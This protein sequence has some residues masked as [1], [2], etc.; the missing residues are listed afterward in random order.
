MSLSESIAH[1]MVT[2]SFANMEKSVEH[3]L[4]ILTRLVHACQFY[5]S[6]QGDYGYMYCVCVSVCHEMYIHVCI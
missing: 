3:G 6:D 5:D 4:D 1:A 2:G